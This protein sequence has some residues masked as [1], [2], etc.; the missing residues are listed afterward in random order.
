MR[1]SATLESPDQL[2]TGAAD[3]EK[4]VAT[5][6]ATR[7]AYFTELGAFVD[8]PV[9]D[10]SKLRTGDTHKGSAIVE[11]AESTLIVGPDGRFSV[12]ASGNIVVEI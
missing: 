1:V 2:S 12:E 4:A 6:V 3:G 10:R 5:P 8:T 7:S 11:E 9:F